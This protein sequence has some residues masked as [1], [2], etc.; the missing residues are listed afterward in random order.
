EDDLQRLDAFAA[1]LGLAFQVRDDILDVESSSEQLGKTAGKDAAQN[2]S[3]F[4]ALLGMDGAK[5]H[6]QALAERMR[7]QLQPYGE[8]A[9]ALAA[10]A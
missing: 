4:P 7:A 2:K 6:L 3:T 5:R 1:A 10:L 8:D 9:A